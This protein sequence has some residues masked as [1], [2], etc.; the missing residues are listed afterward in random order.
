MKDNEKVVFREVWENL[1]STQYHDTVSIDDY[2][3][4]SLGQALEYGRGS[5][6]NIVSDVNPEYLT[7]TRKGSQLGENTH[8]KIPISSL[9]YQTKSE[10]C[11]M[12]EKEWVK[13][14]FNPLSHNTVSRVTIVL[15]ELPG[16]KLKLSIFRFFKEKRAGFKN[17]KK[18]SRDSH[19]TINLDTGNWYFTRTTFNNRKRRAQTN[20][21]PFIKIEGDIEQVFKVSDIFG[22]Y[23]NVVNPAAVR[24]EECGVKLEMTE[25]LVRS[26]NEI[27]KRL[28]QKNRVDVNSIMRDPT[29][30]FGYRLGEVISKWFCERNGIKLP[31]IWN[32][33]FM[34]FYPGIKKIRKSKMKLL[35]AIIQGYGIK[36][37]QV[38]KILN[39]NPV[40]NINDVIA[41][42]ILFGPDF[43]GQIPEEF[44]LNSASEPMG[45][46]VDAQTPVN[47]GEYTKYLIEKSELITTQER[48]NLISTIKSLVGGQPYFLQQIRDHIRIKQNLR[49]LGEIVSIVSKNHD[50]FIEE[51]NRWSALIHHL[52]SDKLTSYVY[53]DNVLE[54]I[55]REY[56]GYTFKVLTNDIEYFEEGQ[57]QNNCVRTY[58]TFYQSVIVSIRKGDKRVTCEFSDGKISQ[59]MAVC[60]EV[61]GDEWNDVIGELSKRVSK[62]SNQKRIDADIKVEYKRLGKEFWVIIDGKRVSDDDN[63]RIS[64]RGGL[65]LENPNNLNNNG[66]F[67]ELPF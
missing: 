7:Y 32:N 5:K 18:Q 60:N 19:I 57:F 40:I 39:Q 21:N 50:S 42:F 8:K 59:S 35:P 9:Y 55:H 2:R 52:T 20:K 56:R 29:P 4:V 23:R 45:R 25:M 34:N 1:C 36:S 44:I 65:L 66:G 6:T 43:F 30:T 28:N 41:L 46:V 14:A 16:N 17:F 61:P 64:S 10:N 26:F 13:D 27:S 15:S 63:G 47:G 24:S 3:N 33:Y 49:D 31:N 58:L 51:H 67:D 12:V 11:E 38:N 62:L 22:W 37:S 53:C 48:R 54:T